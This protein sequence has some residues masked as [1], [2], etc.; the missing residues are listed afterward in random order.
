MSRI[1]RKETDRYQQ[2]GKDC[3]YKNADNIQLWCGITKIREFS[4][5]PIVMRQTLE[6][7]RSRI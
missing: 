4:N 5:I 1:L 3:A 6:W 2:D 7:I